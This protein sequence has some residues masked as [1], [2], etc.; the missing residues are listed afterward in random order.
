LGRRGNDV[1]EVADDLA[2]GIGDFCRAVG[3]EQPFGSDDLGK[4]A[5][6]GDG[7]SPGFA[8]ESSPSPERNG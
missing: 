7:K 1:A 5:F 3:G 8:Q 2:L 4:A 6:E